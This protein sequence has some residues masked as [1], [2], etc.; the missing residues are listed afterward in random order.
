MSSVSCASTPRLPRSAGTGARS[1]EA[2]LGRAQARRKGQLFKLDARLTPRV[3]DVEQPELVVLTASPAQHRVEG[4]AGER[5]GPPAGARAR[6]GLR[7]L[8]APKRFD[9]ARRLRRSRPSVASPPRRMSGVNHPPPVR[10]TSAGLK[11]IGGEARVRGR[12]SR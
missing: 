9:D 12:T 7:Q 6:E 10:L 3:D 5:T 2:S 1:P 11:L 4:D 8:R